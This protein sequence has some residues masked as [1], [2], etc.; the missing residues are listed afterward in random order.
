MASW[1][2]DVGEA[3]FE[4]RVLV[5]SRRVPVVVDFWAPWCGPC[6]ILGPIL[7]RLAEEFQG[8]FFLAKVNVDENPALADIFRIQGIP[9]VKL[10]KGGEIAAEFAGAAPEE[11]VRE[12]LTRFLPTAADRRA[13][14]A[15]ALED[16]GRGD[17]AKALYMKILEEL[18]NHPGALLGLGR[19]LMEDDG[20]QAVDLLERIALGTEERREA[21]PLIARAKLKEGVDED[22]S[23]LRARLKSEPGDLEARFK[24]AKFL[25]VSERYEEAL[26]EFLAVVKT[27]RNYA[28]DGARKAMIEIFE[29]LGRESELAERYRSELAK[30]L[31]S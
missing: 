10:F 19:L 23:V 14:E 6:R 20:A 31:Y 5:E 16:A 9:A 22:E 2:Q 11:A 24:L 25:A 27:D 30:A 26:A 4:E 7:E 13:Q 17:E 28:E 3:D 8:A 18:P 12:L 1:I 21:E 15:K 29:I